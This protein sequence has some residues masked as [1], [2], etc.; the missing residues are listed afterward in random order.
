MYVLALSD[1]LTPLEEIYTDADQIAV[2]SLV[3]NAPQPLVPAEALPHITQAASVAAVSMF[4]DDLDISTTAATTGGTRYN[5]R[6]H[7][8]VEPLLA[9]ACFR[10]GQSANAT[11][12]LRPVSS[13]MGCTVCYPWL[14]A[15]PS[16]RC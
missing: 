16:H 2:A 6:L 13:I 7:L 11:S 14:T 4:D 8:C 15:K 10:L 12:Q 5:C 9:A 1:C 3:R